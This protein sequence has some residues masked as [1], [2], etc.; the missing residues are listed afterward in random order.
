MMPWFGN[1][2]FAFIYVDTGTYWADN[3]W[4]TPVELHERRKI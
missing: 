1:K 3:F 4:K 2:P